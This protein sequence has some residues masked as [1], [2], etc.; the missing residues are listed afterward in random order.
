MP[1][2]FFLGTNSLLLATS[3]TAARSPATIHNPRFTRFLLCGESRTPQVVFARAS[4][5]RRHQ[6]A[7]SDGVG[8]GTMRRN[9]TAFGKA[10]GVAGSFAAVA[11]S[12]TGRGRGVS[13]REAAEE[14]MF[15]P[16]MSR[17]RYPLQM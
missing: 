1:T 6:A 13:G 12:S 9:V 8:S 3:K 17:D 16:S 14:V 2:S 7:G 4:S 5:S 15:N 11:A 10:I